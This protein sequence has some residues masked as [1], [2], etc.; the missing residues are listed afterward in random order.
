MVEA[1]DDNKALLER[2]GLMPE[3]EVAALLGIAIKTLKNRSR[4]SMPDY[5]KVGRR[6][7]YVVESVRQ[8]LEARRVNCSNH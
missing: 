1:A 5:V 4:Q 2:F 3:S 8:F 6:R 7:Y